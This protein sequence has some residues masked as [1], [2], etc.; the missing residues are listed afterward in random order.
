M[1]V[2]AP[3]GIVAA[4]EG[5]RT[6]SATFSRTDE[7]A[8]R[9]RAALLALGVALV[10]SVIVAASVGAVAVPLKSV[11]E[12]LLH[13]AGL[14]PHPL[15]WSATDA[16]IVLDVRL[17]R[18]ITA[19][20]IGAALS[21]AG[22]LFQALLRNPLADPYSIGTSGGA[23]LGATVGV[24]LSARLGAGWV[25]VPALAFVGAI[26]TTLLVYSL[27]RVGGKTPVVTLLLAGLSVSV[28]L[29]YSVSLLLLMSD[30]LQR[31]L[32]ILYVWLLG[33][34]TTAPWSH[35]G[36]IAVIVVAGCGGALGRAHRLN[37][38]ALGDEAAASLGLR[39]E[40]ERGIVIV[41]GALLTAAAVAGGG[42]IGFVGLI[43]P[44]VGRVL[45][46]PNHDR[47][48]PVSILGGGMFL[49][50]ADLVARVALAPAEIPL[51]I[52]TAFTGGPLFLYL[53][54]RMKQG[55]RF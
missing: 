45:V 19:A 54:R 27:A 23:A 6:R 38:L 51:G 17:P 41:I 50:L 7:S 9:F 8:W 16:T 1:S 3:A 14:W 13:R 53:L 47:L 22:V 15:S 33:G 37:A 40:R 10:A 49:V 21:A 26:G 39:V 24:V 52:V 20:L 5:K 29:G 11:A 35:V 18:V 55:Y 30:R 25:G 48:L 42:V 44:H 43:V 31:D 36:V 2:S 4:G 12:I 34:V 28:I 32:R 46:G